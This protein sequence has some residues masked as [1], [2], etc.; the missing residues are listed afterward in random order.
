MDFGADSD[1]R[2]E[3]PSSSY[4]SRISSTSLE[5]RHG[6]VG[7]AIVGANFPGAA[8]KGDLD[9][10]SIG[11]NNSA[12]ARRSFSRIYAQRG[13]TDFVTDAVDSVTSLNDFDVDKSTTLKPFDVDKTFNLI[14]QQIKCTAPAPVAGLNYAVVS[15]GVVASGTVIPP[16]VEDFGI[17]SGEIDIAVSSGSVC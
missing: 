17:T 5:N 7:F 10:S 15:L 11:V 3:I 16:K 14:D 4:F 1:A 13:F 6:P 8:A 2:Y 12:S 9:T